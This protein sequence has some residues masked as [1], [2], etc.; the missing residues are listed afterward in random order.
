[1]MQL[2]GSEIGE[3]REPTD[4][5][6]GHS[7]LLSCFRSAAVPPLCALDVAV[8][9]VALATTFIMGCSASPDGTAPVT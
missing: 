4:D 8:V 7:E 2:A 9:A 1:M 6:H 5:H 3:L